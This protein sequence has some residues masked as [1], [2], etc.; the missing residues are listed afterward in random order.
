MADP[1]I[2]DSPDLNGLPTNSPNL[3]VTGASTGIP[4]APPNDQRGKLKQL[5]SAFFSGASEAGMKYAGMETPE[6]EQQRKFEN[7]LALRRQTA[8]EQENQTMAEIRKQLAMQS[9]QKALLDA[10]TKVNV[11]NIGAGAKVDVAKFTQ[12]AMMDRLSLGLAS[13]EE[14]TKWVEGQKNE[15]AKMLQR[16]LGS[17]SPLVNAT[18]DITGFYNTKNPL[19]V[20]RA[21]EDIG[22]KTAMSPEAQKVGENAASGLRALEHLSAMIQANPQQLLMEAVPGSLGA[23]EMRAAKNEVADVI[24]RLRTG[25]ALNQEEQDFYKSQLPG[26]LDLSEPEAMNY[27]LG[28][29]KQLFT[30]L[31]QGNTKKP[32]GGG[33][34]INVIRL[35]DGKPGTISESQFDATKY[36]RR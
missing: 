20:I 26:A 28:L 18:G 32:A 34:R 31:S 24:T 5:L 21:P 33:G 1:N 14:L 35:S 6:E 4:L 27:K 12:S 30:G 36:E 25:A 23:R 22:R 29:L 11:A 19:N 2:P 13:K 7:N 15:R 9:G 16:T 17:Y 3:G 10:Q 8:V